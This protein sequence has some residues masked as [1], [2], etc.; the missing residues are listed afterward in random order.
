MRKVV[1]RWEIKK[2][3]YI[4]ELW[5]L[6]VRKAPVLEWIELEPYI[7][8]IN[9]SEEQYQYC[10]GKLYLD[11]KN[12]ELCNKEIEEH[13]KVMALMTEEGKTE[14]EI[15]EYMKWKWT[16]YVDRVEWVIECEWLLE[17]INLLITKL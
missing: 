7:V 9:W 12:N 10:E 11:E 2:T 5:D 15:R 3:R 8:R 1:S 14:E 13:Q 4:K 17:K 16:D 6:D